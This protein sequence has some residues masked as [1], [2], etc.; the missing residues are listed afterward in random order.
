[1]RLS[2]A[3]AASVATLLSACGGASEDDPATVTPTP[4]EVVGLSSAKVLEADFKATR[5]QFDES[6]DEM[7][8]E[9]IPFDDDVYSGR[10]TRDT[11]LDRGAYR[12]Y[13]SVN[14]F[15][16]YIAYFDESATGAVNGAV[17]ASDRY[18]DHGYRGAMYART[19]NVTLPSTTQ[20]AF[21]NGDYVGLRTNAKGGPMETVIGEANMEVDFSDD[22]V[23][24]AINNR[25]VVFS[26]DPTTATDPILSTIVFADSDLSRTNG[27][28]TGGIA[29]PDVD[30]TYEGM[31]AD[32]TTDASEMVGITEIIIGDYSENGTFIAIE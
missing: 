2:L 15:D 12:A 28:F 6:K 1:M 4:G 14:G 3:V 32:G 23:R 11:S 5:I 25:A 10:Y 26:T 19:G 24:G 20:R 8:I 18:L 30:G 29:T 21:Y 31:L 22:T 9:A 7:I 13:V 16:N 27:T 17:V